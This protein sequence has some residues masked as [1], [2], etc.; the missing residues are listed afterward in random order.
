MHIF[1]VKR[2]LNDVKLNYSNK[3]DLKPSNDAGG[4]VYHPSRENPTEAI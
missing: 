3:S 4:I 2:L 1:I